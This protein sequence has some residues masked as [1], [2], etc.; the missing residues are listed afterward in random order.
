MGEVDLK[1]GFNRFSIETSEPIDIELLR[2]DV[3]G[4]D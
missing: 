3:E 1:R 4:P 2:F